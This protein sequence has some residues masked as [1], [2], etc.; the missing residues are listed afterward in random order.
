M[1][2]SQTEKLTESNK[3]IKKPQQ[4]K[5]Q[6]NLALPQ[7]IQNNLKCFIKRPFC[8]FIQLGEYQEMGLTLDNPS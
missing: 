3:S 6:K 5:Q 4:Q 1:K 2:E 7:L 8:A